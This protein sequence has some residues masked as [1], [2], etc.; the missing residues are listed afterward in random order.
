MP[1]KRRKKSKKKNQTKEE[2]VE[3]NS[4]N[5][6]E[7]SEEIPKIESDEEIFVISDVNPLTLVPSLPSRDPALQKYRLVIT[8]VEV[9]NFKSYAGHRVIGPFDK[10]FTSIIGP[11]GSGKSNILDALLFAF[12]YS[13]SR[14][15]LKR[16]GE[17]VH[18]SALLT[19]AKK[20]HVKVF[21]AEVE[22]LSDG[23]CN[24]KEGSEFTIKRVVHRKTHTTNYFFNN[25]SIRA[26]DLKEKLKNAYGLDLT[27]HRF[28]IL[29]GEVERIAMMKPKGSSSKDGLL[30]YLEEV[31]GSNRFISVIED[32]EEKHSK[33]VGRL[34]LKKQEVRG[35]QKYVDSM[36]DQR[37]S[38]ETYIATKMEYQKKSFILNRLNRFIKTQEL[39]KIKEM[40][41]QLDEKEQ[42]VKDSQVVKI[43]F[44]LIEEQFEGNIDEAALWI[45]TNIMKLD[46]A[47]NEIKKNL[48]TADSRYKLESKRLSRIKTELDQD[49]ASV[50]KMKDSIRGTEIEMQDKAR[51][52]GI[53]EETHAELVEE[54]TEISEKIQL[55]NS[56]IDEKTAE[57]SDEAIEVRKALGQLQM[58]TL[59]LNES[60]N[61]LKVQESTLNQEIKSLHNIVNV[62]DS[63]LQESIDRKAQYQEQLNKV[64][65]EYDEVK[66]EKE[67][68]E[69]K[70]KRMQAEAKT[71]VGK[72]NESRK[73]LQRLSIEEDNIQRQID[74]VASSSFYEKCA[75][76]FSEGVIGHIMEFVEFDPK[77]ET[78][79]VSA[80][81]G[82]LNTLLVA[83]NEV[84]KNIN[85]FVR[86]QRQ[87]NRNSVPRGFSCFV[88][89]FS[90][91]LYG[92]RL[93]QQEV[94]M[95]AS[96][97][98]LY[99][100]LIFNAENEFAK[101]AFFD[102]LKDIH[103]CDTTEEAHACSVGSFFKNRRVKAVTLDGVLCDTLG[104]MTVGGGNN[105]SNRHKKGPSLASLNKKIKRIVN[106]KASASQTIDECDL[107]VQSIQEIL[108]EIHEQVKSKGL[109]MSDL[110]KKNEVLVENMFVCEKNIRL[111]GVNESDMR[112]NEKMLTAAEKK[113][114][115]VQK[116]LKKSENEYQ[117][118]ENRKLELQQE[119]IRL[120]GHEIQIL[121]DRRDTMNKRYEAV[122]QNLK[123]QKKQLIQLNE[124]ISSFQQRIDDGLLKLEE[125]RK[126]RAGTV[127]KYE[128]ANSVVSKLS[129]TLEA[130]QAKDRE[131]GLLHDEM[132]EHFDHVKNEIKKLEA[133]LKAIKDRRSEETTRMKKVSQVLSEIKQ[134][135]L[136]CSEGICQ[137][138]SF[139]NPEIPTLAE[140]RDKAID[141][142]KQHMEEDE[143]WIT[144]KSFGE[145]D[146]ADI[147]EFQA[148]LKKTIAKS[149]TMFEAMT[150]VDLNVLKLYRAAYR[151]YM[152]FQERYDSFYNITST[153]ASKLEQLRLT[154]H[155]IFLD[156]FLE[157][158]AKLRELYQTLTL[159][160]DAELERRD[161]LDPFSEG[162]DFTVRPPK[163]SWKKIVNLSGGEKTLASL[164]LIF[165]LHS[166]RP[167][168]LY[169]MDEID[170]ALDFR[171][172]S[173]VA[174]YLV[175]KTQ[176]AQF[177][178]VSLRNNMFEL[179]NRLIGVYKTDDMT[180]TS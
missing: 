170:A 142:M 138:N 149:K 17:L 68:L 140:D 32:Y 76:H 4:E 19:D 104:A 63:D 130:L 160:G 91:Q 86:S 125:A 159:G 119:Y 150:D 118:A 53:I 16:V 52:V 127:A 85:N 157:I 20:A 153:M 116:K 115:K 47:I 89:S 100:C 49:R 143:N 124:Y 146:E 156:G 46:K 117:E 96:V 12:G 179:A 62:S 80:F 66:E 122:S 33:M 1:S 59:Q 95:N 148:E 110:R 57:L 56:Q 109:I 92:K 2:A 64:I 18:N 70:K 177:I 38:A 111:L 141:I 30:E 161:R 54:Q 106:Q 5:M 158:K 26:A 71:I 136:R 152:Q 121:I 22:D 81:G 79:I 82:Q 107:Q 164:A 60:R 154:R 174:N 114:G 14:L 151:D 88:P 3:E 11:N 101:G 72:C 102:V 97:K 41:Q 99:D 73:D 7:I 48:F 67:L 126:K 180:K 173:I 61:E 105:K 58:D 155:K 128:K 162:I 145:M 29:Q 24:I 171:N 163:K 168:P 133:V 147:E 84:A 45:R 144:A 90:T 165:A 178:V 13:A 35:K 135:N 98:R 34:E 137:L 37:K 42:K 131:F 94:D 50:A 69:E 31:I 23:T 83:S 78:A 172:V 74:S 39:N 40:L 134:T 169:V 123:E 21:F 167:N 166:Y 75:I 120:G 77:Y 51:S 28:L 103:V 44:E 43:E 87:T 6:V 15:R 27:N 9:F 108:K 36:N 132:E 8:Q 10:R 139:L 112:N 113:L 55:C 176:H 65:K 93:N 175:E 129:E 25:E